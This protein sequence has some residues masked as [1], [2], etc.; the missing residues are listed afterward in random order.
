MDVSIRIDCL[1]MPATVKHLQSEFV[2]VVEVLNK[3]SIIQT[4]KRV[5]FHSLPKVS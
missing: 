4:Y 2:D 1:M 3:Q 5:K